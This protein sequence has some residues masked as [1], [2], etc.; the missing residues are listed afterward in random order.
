MEYFK[1][2]IEFVT[3]L[4]MFFLFFYFFFGYRSCGSEPPNQRS[5]LHPLHWKTESYHCITREVPK[6]IFNL[7][8]YVEIMGVGI[9]QKELFYS[10]P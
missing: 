8:E 9:K 6:R 10:T 1:I 4:F 5:K 3:M 7:D 2:F